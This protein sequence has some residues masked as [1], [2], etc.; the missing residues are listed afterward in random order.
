MDGKLPRH[1]NGLAF[2]K[3]SIHCFNNRRRTAEQP[4]F[5]IICDRAGSV[6]VGTNDGLS[7]FRNGRFTVFKT[8]DGLVSNSAYVLHESRDGSIWIGTRNGLSR[9]KDEQFTNW[10]IDSGLS[11]NQIVS[12]YE[13][14]DGALWIG[15][16]NG[17]LNR[18]KNGEFAHIT[19][20]SG[21]Y[22]NLVLQILESEGDLWMCGNKGIYRVSLQE[23]NDFADGRIPAI[24]SYSYGTA[25]GMLTRECTGSSQAGWKTRDGNLW[26]PTAKG[27][28]KIDPKKRNSQ[29]PLVLI[30]KVLL[31]DKVFSADDFP[32]ITPEQENLEINYTAV[33]WER[34]QHIKFKYQLIGL[35]RDWIDAGTRRT[36]Y[37]SHIPPGEYTFRVIADNGDGVW[38]LEGKSLQIKVLPPFYRTWWF[39]GLSIIGFLAIVYAAYQYRIKQL[40]RKNA[41]QEMF[42]RQLIQSQEQERTRIAANLHDSLGQQLLVIK[43]WAMLE[44]A[45]NADTDKSHEALDEISGT[46][47]EAIEEVREIIYDLRP[48]QLDKIGLTKTLRYMIEKVAAASNV[49]FKTE[50]DEIDDL[51]DYNSEITLYRIVQECLNNI[52]K[53]SRAKLATIKIKKDNRQVKMIIQDDGCGFSPEN[54]N[55]EAKGGGFGLTGMAE[56]V[57]MLGGTQTISS[58]PDGGTEIMITVVVKE[59]E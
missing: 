15:T 27:L 23:L 54:I 16:E 28:V 8:S 46:A 30:E 42:A 49:E 11:S 34:P 47:S 19:S 20:R 4:R 39:Y 58:A 38:N 31:D 51:F 10:T 24:T 57:R 45:M 1:G 18:Y 36:A 41:Q 2:A 14:N 43:N 29:P 48:Y 6:W 52:V 56:R 40:E 21:L 5:S 50:I 35:D 17:G 12:F 25:D 55:T 32:Q 37:Y 22:D 3:R 44:L 9:Y 7:V 59:N 13:S 26:F 53:H 33:S